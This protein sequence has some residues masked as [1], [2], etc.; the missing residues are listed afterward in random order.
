MSTD[1]NLEIKHI[2]GQQLG[3]REEECLPCPFSKIE[4]VP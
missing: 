4:K 3:W 2:C 1:L